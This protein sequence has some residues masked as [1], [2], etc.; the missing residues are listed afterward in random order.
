MATRGHRLA[1]FDQGVPPFGR[2]LKL[3]C[4]DHNGTYLLPY[5]CKWSGDAWCNS[6]TGV[7]IEAKVVGWTVAP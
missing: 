7:A 1:E 3:L 5:L 6:V 4:E 2:P